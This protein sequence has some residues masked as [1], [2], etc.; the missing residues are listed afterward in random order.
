[1]SADSSHFDAVVVGSGFGG[2]ITA[3]RLA[4]EGKSVLVLERGREWKPDAFPRDVTQTET[5]F[6]RYPDAPESRGLYELHVFSGMAAVTASGL[7]GGS[8]VYANIHIR[9]DPVVF[10]DPAWPD[11]LDRE[12][13]DPYYDRVA[14]LLGVSPLPED[15]DV[16]KRDRFRSAAEKTG[17]PVFDPDQAV[18]WETCDLIAE[19][20]FG[21]PRGA[22]NTLDR[23]VLP[24]AEERGAQIR[25]GSW[26]YGV[27]PAG[28]GYTVH[29][30]DLDTR[31]ENRVQGQ[32]VVLSAGTLGTGK[33]LHRSAEVNGTLPQLSDRLGD[34]VSANGDF[35]ASI[36]SSREPLNPAYGP[37]VTSVIRYFDE[38]PRFT[39]AAPTFHKPAMRVLAS[40]GQPSGAFLRPF[41]SLLWPYLGSLI[42]WIFRKGLM[43]RPAPIPFPNAGD[44][45]RLTFLFG[46]G[47]DNAGGEMHLQDGQLDV[48][49]DYAKENRDLVAATQNAMEDL[50]EAAYGGTVAPIVTW[51]GFRRP[52]SVH[53]LGGCVMGD[54]RDEGVVSPD[55]EVYGYP[56]LFVADGS[57]IPSSIG[58]HP[59][60]TIAAVSARISDAVAASYAS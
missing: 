11:A 18:D 33:I 8:L 45:D 51:A 54:S 42:P 29:Y 14:D 24:R 39:M 12:A 55:G 13:L 9:P 1:M 56:G 3:L 23:T 21:C 58:F 27:E 38:E 37:D 15:L 28:D 16:P 4:E 53:P 41:A 31:E 17:R 43:S 40:M 36:Q 10:E 60:M 44:P 35:L 52:L 57:V 32:R 30:R 50:N 19:C 2:S 49:W 34:G 46:I 20:E 47:R 6:W 5:L 25:T 22:K 48:A 26:V 59:A 7:G